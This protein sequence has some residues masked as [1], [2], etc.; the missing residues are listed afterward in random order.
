M[1]REWTRALCG[2]DSQALAALNAA[3][4][5]IDVRAASNCRVLWRGP[6]AAPAT[7]ACSPTHLGRPRPLPN[8]PMRQL[9][10]LIASPILVGLLMQH[11]GRQPMAVATAALLAWNLLAWAPEVLLLRRALALSPAL[12]A[13]RAGDAAK[14]AAAGSAHPGGGGGPLRRAAAAWREQR[15]AWALYARQPAAAAALALAL[16]YLTVMSWG[17][18]MTA[19]LKALGLPEAELA[20]YRG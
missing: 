3:M 11:G 1:E 4:K 7:R 9:T 6:A 15:G 16:I 12:A 19:Y 8:T 5:R 2:G 17:T 14:A 13:P 20:V 18:L 10:C